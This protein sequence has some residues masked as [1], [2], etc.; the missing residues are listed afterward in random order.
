MQTL[1]R[2]LG[3]G[4]TSSRLIPRLSS[5]FDEDRPSPTGDC[6]QD[7]P[8][9][10][11]LVRVTAQF[12]LPVSSTQLAFGQLGRAALVQV[13]VCFYGAGCCV[14]AACGRAFE[15]A[16]QRGGA[17]AA[18]ARVGSGPFFPSL[19]P[20]LLSCALSVCLCLYPLVSTAVSFSFAQDSVP[21]VRLTAAEMIRVVLAEK[22]VPS[23]FLAELA[24]YALVAS[25]QKGRRRE[26]RQEPREEKRSFR[27]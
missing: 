15:R 6:E 27:C 1:A 8:A 23:A 21:N 16:R 25:L 19:F 26:R 13:S 11:Y 10:G 7:A 12:A 5:F 4:W 3:D 9:S 2:V 20:K 14:A 18:Q 24:P 17:A 22:T